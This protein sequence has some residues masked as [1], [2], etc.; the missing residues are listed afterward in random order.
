MDSYLYKLYNDISSRKLGSIIVLLRIVF[1]KLCLVSKI[2]FEE[3][4]SKLIS[5]SEDSKELQ[6][7]L[8]SANFSDKFLVNIQ[9]DSECS[10]EDLLDYTN[11]FIILQKNITKQHY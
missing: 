7:E 4:I 3:D 6:K 2:Y 11:K 1:G 5:S 10:F 9:M 8:K